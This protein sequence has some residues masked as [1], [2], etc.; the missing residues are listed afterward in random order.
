MMILQAFGAR[1]SFGPVWRVYAQIHARVPARV[2]ARVHAFV[3]ARLVSFNPGDLRWAVAAMALRLLGAVVAFAERQ[4]AH[5]AR[6][7][8]RRAWQGAR[9]AAE[10]S[11]RWLLPD[12]SIRPVNRAESRFLHELSSRSKALFRAEPKKGCSAQLCSGSSASPATHSGIRQPHRG[13]RDM[14]PARSHVFSLEIER[15]RCVLARLFLV[16]S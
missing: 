13:M 14:D 3:L 15:A 4:L 8:L 10:M 7:V 6:R 16:R 5:W 1:E 2:L 9:F 12:A 11:D